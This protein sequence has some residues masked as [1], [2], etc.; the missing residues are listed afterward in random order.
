[1][2]FVNWLAKS[3]GWLLSHAIEG[4]ITVAMSFLALASFYIFDSLVMKLTGF[5]GSFIVGYLAAYCLGKLRGDD[6]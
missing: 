5:F 6:R 2:K 3:I 1:M 4:T